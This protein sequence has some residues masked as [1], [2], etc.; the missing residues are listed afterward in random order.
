MGKVFV[1]FL[2]IFL[3][4]ILFVSGYLYLYFGY[5]SKP[6]IVTSDSEP[7]SS[8][9]DT[10]GKNISEKGHSDFTFIKET[11]Q[12]G[13]VD[14]GGAFDVCD[15]FSK[16]KYSYL[17]PWKEFSRHGMVTESYCDGNNHKTELWTCGRGFVC[18][19]GACVEGKEDTSICTDTDGGK[20]YAVRG[21]IYGYGGSG[22]DYCVISNTDDPL[23]GSGTNKCEGTGCYIYEYYCGPGGDTKQKEITK[24]SNC[25]QGACL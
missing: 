20:N 2:V 1:I 9:S 5:L 15:Y 4:L 12:E 25:S 23:E 14:G 18:R 17:E 3:I 24:C 8:C 6:R 19:D 16:P 13:L 11:G 21:N 22:E 10:D 7:V